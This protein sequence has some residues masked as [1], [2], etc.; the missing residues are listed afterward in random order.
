[1]KT[2]TFE[3]LVKKARWFLHIGVH[4]PKTMRKEFI[5]EAVKM[6][7][8]ADMIYFAWIG[9]QMMDAAA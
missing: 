2:P 4:R 3:E 7:A 5:N 1:M 9:A 8:S 6:G